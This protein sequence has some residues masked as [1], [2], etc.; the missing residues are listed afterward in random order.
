MLGG[1]LINK[2]IREDRP[3]R[4]HSQHTYELHNQPNNHIKTTKY[5]NSNTMLTTVVTPSHR[6]TIIV[7][8]LLISNSLI[9]NH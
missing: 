9:T 6:T 8:P 1:N 4:P 7:A 2:D 5:D 3:S